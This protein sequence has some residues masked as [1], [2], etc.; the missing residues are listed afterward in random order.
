[1]TTPA[2]PV[3]GPSSE[4]SRDRPIGVF[5]SGI[6]GLT[7]VREI[8]RQLPAERV[9][10]FG[11]SARVPYGGKSAETVTRFSIENTHFLLRRGIK[12]LVVAC[13]TA[14]A[15]ALPVLQRRFDVP[16]IG[17][18]VPGAR[19]A[20]RRS[21]NRKI[22]VIGTTGTIGSEA[23]ER[24]IGEIA[25]DWRVEG[26]ACPL[27]VPLAEEGWTEGDVPR[28]VAETYLAPLRKSGVDTVILGCTHYPILRPV[29]AEVLGEEISLVDTAEATVAEVRREL[30][31]RGL[32]RDAG[33]ARGSGGHAAGGGPLGTAMGEHRFFLSDVPVRFREIG[34]R[35]LGEPIE[36]LTWVEQSDIP[37]YER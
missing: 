37:W 15:L 6:G 9:I 12:F 3:A 36:D 34:G 35:F 25:A 20:V 24:A 26:A 10:Y 14:S 27:F 7:V 21:K 19:E 11:D 30:G 29:I 22:G 4:P 16:M 18:I 1:M 28:R 2:L 5:D 23:Y 8:L 32:L 31:E 13:N 33:S 17:V